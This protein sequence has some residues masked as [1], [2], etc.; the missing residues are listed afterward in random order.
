M[1]RYIAEL[2]GIEFVGG[3]ANYSQMYELVERLRN[4]PDGKKVIP[5]LFAFFEAHADQVIGSPGPFVHFI[6]EAG[7]YHELLKASVSRK[8]TDLTLWMVNRI[9]NGGPGKGERDEWLKVL[10]DAKANPRADSEA[11][12]AAEEFLELQSAK[13]T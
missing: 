4:D 11:Q 13:T 8:P 2:D 12:Q 10:R 9:L 1:S 6:E 3:E 5:Y 7:G